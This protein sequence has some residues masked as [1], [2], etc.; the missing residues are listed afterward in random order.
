MLPK[1]VTKEEY[2]KNISEYGDQSD[3]KNIFAK[4]HNKEEEMTDKPMT[5]GDLREA[6]KEYPDDMEVFIW[7]AEYGEKASIRLVQRKDILLFQP[8]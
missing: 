6:I 4:L 8:E 2:E 3:L 5:V 1:E 7:D